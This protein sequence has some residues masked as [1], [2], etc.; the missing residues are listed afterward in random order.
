VALGAVA[1]VTASCGPAPTNSWLGLGLDA[2]RA[3][4]AGGTHLYAVNL[5]DGKEVWRFPAVGATTR[6]GGEIFLAD[7]AVSEDV[8]VVGSWGP[9]TSHSG[10]VYGLNPADGSQKW[11]VVF[12]D[13]AATDLPVCQKSP[14]ATAFVLG[15]FLPPVDNRV[16][17][18]VTLADGMAYFGM[19]NNHVYAVDASDGTVKWVFEGSKNP[20]WAAPLVDG[21]RLIVS[22]FDKSV[23]A[24]DRATGA[25]LWQQDLGAA[26][27]SAPAL[28]DGTLYVG[29][30]GNQVVALDSAT[31]EQGWAY[32]TD[33]WIWDTPALA[34]GVLYFTDLQGAIYAVNAADGSEV[35][36]QAAG[37]FTRAAPAVHDGLLYVVDHNG[38]VVGLSA[39]DGAERWRQTVKGQ[40]QATPL[41]ALEQDLVLIRPYQGDSSVTAFAL[42]GSRVAWAYQPTQ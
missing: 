6:S 39:V 38:N 4:L 19:A 1:V 18:G 17:G 22:S 25:V 32:T 10:A 16:V 40:L 11:C 41:V 33:Y 31:G 42:D 29:T 24:L 2:E 30:F 27:A 26:I 21:D 3:Y 12:D 5:T 15:F 8:I 13:K 9:G 35:W 7:P 28:A 20:V 36:R 37:G 23:Y 34:D 14:D